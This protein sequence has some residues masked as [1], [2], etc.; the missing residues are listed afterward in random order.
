MGLIHSQTLV[1]LVASHRRE[2]V[3]IARSE[4]VVKEVRGDFRCRG[5]AGAQATINLHLSAFHI[6][7]FIHGEGVADGRRGVSSTGIEQRQTFNTGF[8][9]K[10]DD[11]FGYGVGG[12]GD[13]LASGFVDDVFGKE[14]AIKTFGQNLV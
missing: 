1:E 8:L 2:V 11:A 9:Q 10:F 5:G 14:G 13:N 6:R 7:G 4:Q 12:F 3:V